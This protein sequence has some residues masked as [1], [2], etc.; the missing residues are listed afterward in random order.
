M[1]I[2]CKLTLQQT[3][4]KLIYALFDRKKKNRTKHAQCLKIY[5]L[6]LGCL[7]LFQALLHNMG[8]WK[9]YLTFLYFN[10]IICS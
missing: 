3:F 5:S 6:E 8:L 10:Y 2:T 9:I 1:D 4:A 7:E